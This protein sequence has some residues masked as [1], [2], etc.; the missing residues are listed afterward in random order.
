LLHYAF[1]QKTNGLTFCFYL[2]HL[3]LS[4]F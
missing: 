1:A 3:A 2:L 4:C